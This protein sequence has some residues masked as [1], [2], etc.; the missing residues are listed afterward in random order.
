[1]CRSPSLAGVSRSGIHCRRLTEYQ[2]VYGSGEFL[3]FIFKH[4]SQRNQLS[5]P[6]DDIAP[7]HSENQGGP[8]VIAGVELGAVRGEAAAVVHGDGVADSGLARAFGGCEDFD[9]GAVGVCGG[10]CCCEDQEGG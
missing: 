10:C 1:V 4:C 8:S 3:L 7:T 6:L 5:S 9:G 2:P